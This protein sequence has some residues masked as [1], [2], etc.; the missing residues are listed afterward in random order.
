MRTL[1][2]VAVLTASCAAQS[3]GQ[4]NLF[5]PCQSPSNPCTVQASPQALTNASGAPLLLQG[6]PNGTQS[7]GSTTAGATLAMGAN[8]PASSVSP[9]NS[10]GGNAY[11]GGGVAIQSGNDAIEGQDRHMSAWRLGS[12]STPGMVY[13]VSGHHQVDILSSPN[14]IPVGIMPPAS[15]T[16]GFVNPQGAGIWIQ[17]GGWTE[18][19]KSYGPQSFVAGDRVCTDTTYLGYVVDGGLAMCA[20]PSQQIGVSRQSDGQL[21][22]HSVEIILGGCN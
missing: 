18:G 16:D 1:L 22:M 13:G 15:P 7:V 9:Y 8:N 14:Q 20:C 6:A 5:T 3:F 11:Y 2:A 17:W 4:S 12:T 19:V 10:A 21:N